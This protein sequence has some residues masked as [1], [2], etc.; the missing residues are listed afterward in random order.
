MHIKR[1]DITENITKDIIGWDV[2][3]W[4]GG[5][6][7]WEEHVEWPQIRQALEL[8]GREGGLSLWLALKGIPTVC[9]DLS[10]VQ[11]TASPLHENYPVGSLIRYQDID[12]TRIPYND[13]F[14]IIVFKSILG[15]IGRN[16]DK[17]KQREVLRQIHKALKPGGKLLFAENLI[18]SPV[19]QKLRKKA[20][21]WG[22]YWRYISSEEM[23]EFL[24]D[25]SGFEIKTTG[26][27]ATLGRTEKQRNFL[28]GLDRLC[29]N[30]IVPSSWHYII[31]GYAVK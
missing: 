29:F 30:K 21:N 11:R 16:N 19:H 18:S 1:R 4:S 20:L 10:D 22:N 3:S 23:R 15:G 26:F 2:K 5:L 14:D 8:G 6:H 9:S 28:A 7:F 12:A 27:T 13:Y 17:E 25:F 31:Y 24:A